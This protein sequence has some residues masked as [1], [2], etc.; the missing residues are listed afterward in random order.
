MTECI[1]CHKLFN[2][3]IEINGVKKWSSK[4]K[5][6]YECNP[7]G[8]RKFTG[9]KGIIKVDVINDTLKCGKCKQIKSI[10]LF[11][12]D[13]TRLTGYSCYCKD[14]AVEQ[15]ISRMVKFKLKCLDYLT[16]ECTICGYNK[17]IA[18]LDFHHKD[19]TQKDVLISRFKFYTFDDR[20]KKELDKCIVLCANCHRELH[21]SRKDSNL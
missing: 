21:Y 2:R 6:C 7:F 1:I 8:E 3:T 5:I 9:G 14:C 11:N 17:C 10:E 12:Q 15:T 16:H 13:Q 4:R 19:P 18:A 20:V